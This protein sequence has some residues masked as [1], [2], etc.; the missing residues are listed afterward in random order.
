MPEEVNAA[1]A[2]NDAKDAVEVQAHQALSVKFQLDNLWAE[3]PGK[4]PS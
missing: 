2:G 3:R 4:S 1:S